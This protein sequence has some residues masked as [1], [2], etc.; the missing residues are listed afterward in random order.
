MSSKGKKTIILLFAFLLIIQIP[1]EINGRPIYEGPIYEG[2]T[3]YRYT[4]KGKVID[5]FTSAGIVATNV[6]FYQSGIINKVT[7]TKADGTF[8]YSFKTT[9]KITS[10]SIYISKYCYI[11][12]TKKSYSPGTVINLGTIKL[13]PRS[14]WE[15]YL[16]SDDAIELTPFVIQKAQEACAGEKTEAGCRQAIFDYFTDTKNWEY[17]GGTD[18]NKAEWLLQQGSG[19]D[20]DCG[21]VAIYTCAMARAVG[22][23]ARIVSWINRAFYNYDNN[24]KTPDITADIDYHM[25][26]ELY[27]NHNWLISDLSYNWYSLDDFRNSPRI[28]DTWYDMSQWSLIDYFYMSSGTIHSR[29]VSYSNNPYQQYIQMG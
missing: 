18:L 5:R 16:E 29:R 19:Y 7:K 13:T 14:S 4:I 21:E 22:I 15:K 23:P 9:K 3:T 27:I 2:P 12:T 24:P 17:V 6:E 25:F 8:Y 20:W 1:M 28:K 10:L 26:A 11:T